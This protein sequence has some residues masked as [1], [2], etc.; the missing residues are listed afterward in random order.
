M[1]KL[2]VCCFF[3][4]RFTSALSLRR[5]ECVNC[6]H[7]NVFAACQS[8]FK[9]AVRPIAVLIIVQS[10]V[11]ALNWVFGGF[12]CLFILYFF[13][14]RIIY[15]LH[16]SRADVWSGGRK[17]QCNSRMRAALARVCNRDNCR[18]QARYQRALISAMGAIVCVC[19]CILSSFS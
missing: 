5:D 1:H 3:C 15:L 7:Y 6:A 16:S 13:S 11:H 10:H 18:W 4:L 14:G 2:C 8:Q 17:C 19:V 12:G 9:D